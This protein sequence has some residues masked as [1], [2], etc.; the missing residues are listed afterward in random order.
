[1]LTAAVFAV[2][3]AFW[4]I[5]W[6]LGEPP[7]FPEMYWKSAIMIAIVATP[8]VFAVRVLFRAWWNGAE[9]RLS[10]MDGPAQ[11]LSVASAT[12]P[13]DP[14]DW[15]SAMLAELA[16]VRGSSERWQFAA[17]CTWAALFP[18]RSSRTPII[19]AG[20]F[21]AIAV[22][23]ASVA[24]GQMLPAMRGFS[25]TF[26]ALVGALA[27]LTVARSP[28]ARIVVPAPTIQ[29]VGIA[30][31]AACIA[32]TA[33]FLIQNPTATEYFPP[34]AVV[35][36]AVALAGCFWLSLFPPRGLTA[37]RFAR[38][39]GIGAALAF[40]LGFVWIARLSVHTLGG[41]IIWILFAPIVIFFVASGVAAAVG[42]SFHAGIEAAVWTTLIST[43]FVFALSLPEA[44]HRYAIDGRTLGDGESGYAIGVNLPGAIW[45][46][47]QIPIFGL[48]FGV[49]GAAVGRRLRGEPSNPVLSEN[50]PC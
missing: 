3:A 24:V 32:A 5:V 50:L 4:V 45:S 35:S 48:P 8:W 41:P 43:L 46:L 28:R 34:I 9:A 22:M 12:L 16:Q 20:M 1:M 15:G 11:L 38:G 21:A 36:L 30:V 26:V 44:M 6:A 29:V 33:Y 31:V 2:F 13:D 14:R 37:N 17:G 25:I 39:V 40:G 49:F 27:V 23:I 19:L 7:E 42:R 47:L 10:E 18:P